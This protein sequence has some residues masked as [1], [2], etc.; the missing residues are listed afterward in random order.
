MKKIYVWAIIT[1]LGLLALFHLM[2]AEPLQT[3]TDFDS[4]TVVVVF[5]GFGAAVVF[6]LAAMFPKES[7]ST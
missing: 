2:F 4:V 5:L 6:A 3:G 1:L 7:P